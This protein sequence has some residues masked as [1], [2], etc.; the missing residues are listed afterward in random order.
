[1]DIQDVHHRKKTFF[2]VHFTTDEDCPSSGSYFVYKFRSRCHP[3]VYLYSRKEPNSESTT[4]TVKEVERKRIQTEWKRKKRENEH[5]CPQVTSSPTTPSADLETTTPTSVS[6]LEK[7]EKEE[8][9]GRKRREERE[10]RKSEREERREEREEK[11][12]ERRKG[13]GTWDDFFS[14][15]RGRS[16]TLLVYVLVYVC[17]PIYWKYVCTYV[18]MYVCTY[19][20]MWVGWFLFVCVCV[21]VYI[22]CVYIHAC[23]YEDMVC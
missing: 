13:T 22:L 6:V 23:M 11:E 4:G 12:R 1:M 14:K 21:C 15:S 16:Q 20:W 10:E 17:I 9:K 7:S 3:S 18:R 8:K 2:H 5:S 19:V